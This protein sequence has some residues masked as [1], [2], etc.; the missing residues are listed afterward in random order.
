MGIIPARGGSKG[1]PNKNISRLRGR[2]LI[3]YSIEAAKGSRLLDDFFVSTDC[4][5]IDTHPRSMYT[6]EGEKCYH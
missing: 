3:A 4:E 1:I 2:P 6:K 5:V